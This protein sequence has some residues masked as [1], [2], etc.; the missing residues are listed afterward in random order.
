MVRL[1]L[2]TGRPFAPLS[3]LVRTYEPP[4]ARLMLFVWPLPFAITMALFSAAMSPFGMLKSAA[5]VAERKAKIV[6]A[7]NT[8]RTNREW[9]MY[10]DNA[11]SMAQTD[12]VA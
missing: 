8:L 4:L 10:L 11:D 6:N 9:S 12:H 3:T 1:P 7:R 5:R 2:I